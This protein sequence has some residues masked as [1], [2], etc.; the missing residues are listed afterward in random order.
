MVGDAVAAA[1]GLEVARAVVPQA[2]VVEVFDVQ[3]GFD[4]GGGGVEE[5][6]GEGVGGE[7]EG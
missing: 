6:V 4:D 2:D 3:G 7:V 1:V 5:A